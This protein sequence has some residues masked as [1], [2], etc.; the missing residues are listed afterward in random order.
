MRDVTRIGLAL[1]GILSLG[2]FTPASAADPAGTL[3]GDGPAAVV[4]ATPPAAEQ[5]QATPAPAQPPPPPP[6]P[7]G[8]APRAKAIGR[9]IPPPPPPPPADPVNIRVEVVLK[10]QRG[11]GVAV[12][13]NVM[14]TAGNGSW[15]RLR[16]SVESREFGAAP[17]NVDARPRVLAGGLVQL[18]LTVEYYLGQPADPKT[19]IVKTG[20]NESLNVILE[21][22][23]PLLVTQSADPLS[24]RRV[25]MEVKATVLR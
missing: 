11:D 15:G 24:E 1:A 13:K 3:D 21:N 17:L 10:E 16:S 7:A 5:A 9:E 20:L 6:A 25:T 8:K 19:G 22:G 18:E 14:V 12:Q 23:K 2:V 4:A